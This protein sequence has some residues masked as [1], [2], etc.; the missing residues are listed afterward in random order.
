[1]LK[2]TQ[3]W[4]N[5]SPSKSA[6]AKIAETYFQSYFYFSGE[7]EN[8]SYSIAYAI[9]TLQDSYLECWNCLR[10]DK[11]MRVWNSQILL[12]M[13]NHIIDHNFYSTKN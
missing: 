3:I 2:S 6:I 7:L 13:S 11:D 4:K 10:F 12:K 1:M 5:I 8:E 9:K